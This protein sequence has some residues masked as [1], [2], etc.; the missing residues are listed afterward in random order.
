MQNKEATDL[1][2]TNVFAANRYNAQISDSKGYASKSLEKV[3]KT[4]T[5]TKTQPT[6]TDSSLSPTDSDYL[7][8]PI[9][10]SYQ[11]SLLYMAKDTPESVSDINDLDTLSAANQD[12][13]SMNALL[14]KASDPSLS[15]DDRAQCEKM[16]A[17]HKHSLDA[18]GNAYIGKV[19]AAK[20]LNVAVPKE[21]QNDPSKKK[22]PPIS[23]TDILGVSDVT[24]ATAKNTSASLVLVNNASNGVNT[25]ITSLKSQIWNYVQ[26]TKLKTAQTTEDNTKTDKADKEALQMVKSDLSKDQSDSVL[27][28]VSGS[29]FSQSV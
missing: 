3:I 17:Y 18:I 29:Q 11:L 19:N 6:C 21:E 28:Q 16:I 27:S 7:D 15:K 8:T 13:A 22:T 1:E 25:R 4:M 14:E 2:I 5:S 20:K 10:R 12:L 24:A 26:S 23:M 9:A